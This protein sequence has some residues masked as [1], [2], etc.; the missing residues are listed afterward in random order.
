MRPFVP[1]T[2]RNP[3]APRTVIRRPPTSI[4]RTKNTCLFFIVVI[5][6]TTFTDWPDATD[7][8]FDPMKMKFPTCA[9][10]VPFDVASIK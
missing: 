4:V 7:N 8:G 9:S 5:A 6:P 3:F 10:T 2:I 1:G